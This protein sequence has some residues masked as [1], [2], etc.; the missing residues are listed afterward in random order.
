VV[1]GGANA[2]GIAAVPQM[3]SHK[4]NEYTGEPAAERKGTAQR[5]AGRFHGQENSAENENMT[6]DMC[7]TIPLTGWLGL[8][9]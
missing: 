5:R 8:Q 9:R 4:Q 7:L 6:W 1:G 3:D 2:S